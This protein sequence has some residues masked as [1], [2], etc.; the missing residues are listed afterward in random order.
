MHK[1]HAYFLGNNNL[2]GGAF[3]P[4]NLVKYNL[5]EGSLGNKT[6]GGEPIELVSLV[7][8]KYCCDMVELRKR[9]CL[10]PWYL[11]FHIW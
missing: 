8:S 9:L 11:M 5:Y 1:L 3:S 10:Y 4:K 2:K 6:F 7:S